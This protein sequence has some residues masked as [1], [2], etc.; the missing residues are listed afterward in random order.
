M[1]VPKAPM[2]TPATQPED[3]TLSMHEIHGTGP[4]LPLLFLY[5][6]H[7]LM[8]NIMSMRELYNNCYMVLYVLMGSN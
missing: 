7:C 6:E 8:P 1:T 3:C 5:I 4:D 2:P